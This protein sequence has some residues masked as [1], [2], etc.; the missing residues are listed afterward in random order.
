[1]REEKR[2]SLMKKNCMQA[3]F[4]HCGRA[5]RMKG[6]V[7]ACPRLASK[8]ATVIVPPTPDW[9]SKKKHCLISQANT[10]EGGRGL[11]QRTQKQKK[12]LAPQLRSFRV[13]DSCTWPPV[14][15]NQNRDRKLCIS[16]P[17]H[18]SNIWLSGRPYCI[19]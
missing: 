4:S 11:Q 18:S 3:E 17:G 6:N 8:I 9:G 14:K 12:G 5:E 13:T 15:D 10:N 7:E 19:G 1:M 16:P 2:T